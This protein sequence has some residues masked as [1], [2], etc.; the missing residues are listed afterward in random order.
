[1]SEQDLKKNDLQVKTLSQVLR[2]GDGSLKRTPQLIKRILNEGMWMDRIIHATGER[3]KYE[4]HEFAK[5]VQDDPPEG[6]GATVDILKDLCKNDPEALTML[7]KATTQEAGGDR[8]SEEAQIIVDNINNGRSAGTSKDYTL[9]R[10][11]RERPDLYEAVVEGEM[12]ANAAAIKAGFRTKTI[13]VP[14]MKGGEPQ[15]QRAADSLEKHFG[16]D[17]RALVDEL[18]SRLKEPAYQ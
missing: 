13:S 3:Q 14:V 9:D 4:E 18:T 15:I 10:L 5:F 12:S 8:R 17:F 7:R 2:D 1:M 6:L 11:S 16:D